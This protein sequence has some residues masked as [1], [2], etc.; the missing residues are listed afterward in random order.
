MSASA[1]KIASITLDI[2]TLDEME[3]ILALAGPDQL[4]FIYDVGHAQTQDRL[5]F[6][7]H[8][9]WL[10]RYANRIIGAHLHDVIGIRRS[11]GSRS[12]ARSIF[13]WW[14]P[15]FPRMP[16]VPSKY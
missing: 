16:S 3:V 5:G 11:S 7:P 4:G 13:G 8:E 12:G 2:P 6:S 1:L 15:I 10:K 9:G 14:R